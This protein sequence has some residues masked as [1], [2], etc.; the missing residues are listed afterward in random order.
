MKSQYFQTVILYI[1][2]GLAPVDL[3]ASEL[4]ANP[5]TQVQTAETQGQTLRERR[6][7]RMLQY[8]PRRAAR[9]HVSSF[10]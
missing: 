3:V 9:P 4:K 5:K 6:L 8:Q 1:G 2:V 10:V 7:R